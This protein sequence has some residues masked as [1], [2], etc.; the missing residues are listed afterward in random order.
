MTVEES[1]QE[2][3]CWSC[4]LISIVT[5]VFQGN[6]NCLCQSQTFPAEI[7]ENG[8]LGIVKLEEKGHVV[9]QNIR[10]QTRDNE[11]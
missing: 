1:G 11:E 5:T 8:E 10:I 9:R 3:P 6:P 2:S 7:T 4:V